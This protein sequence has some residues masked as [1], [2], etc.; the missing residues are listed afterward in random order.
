MS[1]SNK[2]EPTLSSTP[3][4][5]LD[6][7]SSGKVLNDL[8]PRTFLISRGHIYICLLVVLAVDG[9]E[10]LEQQW[11]SEDWPLVLEPRGLP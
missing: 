4:H 8:H 11:E 5:K 10:E 6:R 7:S 1:Y 2:A 9:G 3:S